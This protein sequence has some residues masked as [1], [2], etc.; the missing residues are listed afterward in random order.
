SQRFL[1][2]VIDA[3]PHVVFV[4]DLPARRILY[5]NQQM[6]SVLGHKPHDL[7]E[8]GSE[9]LPTVTHRDDAGRVDDLLA[10]LAAARDDELIDYELRIK[11]ANGI[12]R[13]L[14]LREVVF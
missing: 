9:F 12:W 4:L 6:E 10:R 5:V 2:R 3:T 11:H 8:L 1:Q 13:S 7:Q 14:Q